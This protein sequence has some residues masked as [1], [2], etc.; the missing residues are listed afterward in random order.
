VEH[1]VEHFA[2]SIPLGFHQLG[3]HSLDLNWSLSLVDVSFQTT[4]P[5]LSARS[6]ARP[7]SR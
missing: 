7:R 2:E 3:F 5:S 6:T 1:S 4:Y